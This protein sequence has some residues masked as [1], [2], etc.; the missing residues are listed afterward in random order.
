[1]RALIV[2]DELI[3]ECEN[4]RNSILSGVSVQC[5]TKRR[6]R[7]GRLIPVDMIGFPN[8]A[9]AAINGI[10]YIYQDISERKAFEKQITH[11]AFHDALTGLPNRT[12][13]GERLERAL[14]R[15]R[16]RPISIMRY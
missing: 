16:R 11:Q 4:V 7:D 13:F 5:E 9:G 1:M 6:H 3:V 12:L 14:E 15:S 2:P 10:T 8:Q